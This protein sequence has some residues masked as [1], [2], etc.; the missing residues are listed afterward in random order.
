MMTLNEVMRAIIAARA[1][2]LRWVA[3]AEALVAGLP[4]DKEQVPVFPT[5]CQFGS[6]YYEQ[7]QVLKMLP[8]YQALETPHNTLHRLYMDIFRMLFDEN[9]RSMPGKLFGSQRSYRKKQMEEAAMLLPMLRTQSQMLLKG[10][11]ML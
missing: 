4:L 6:W 11:D 2:H 10:L 8:S 1:A 7:G 5:D 3:R 9:E